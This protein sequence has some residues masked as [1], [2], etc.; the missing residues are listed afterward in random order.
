LK[1]DE[2]TSQAAASR[3]LLQCCYRDWEPSAFCY[4]PPYCV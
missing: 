4:W 3:Y 2:L 1:A